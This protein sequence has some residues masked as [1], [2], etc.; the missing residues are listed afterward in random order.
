LDCTGDENEYPVFPGMN[1]EFGTAVVV[2]E[3]QTSLSIKVLP[4]MY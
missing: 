1:T 4:V 3:I 2:L